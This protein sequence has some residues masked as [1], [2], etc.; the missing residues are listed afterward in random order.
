M[1]MLLKNW[2]LLIVVLVAISCSKN[3]NDCIDENKMKNEIGCTYEYNPV[4]GCDNKTYSNPCA[5]T[6]YGGV[7]SY[8]A[9]AC[10]VPKSCID[11][12]LICQN[13][14]CTADY[15]PVCGCDGV[16][17]SNGCIATSV[18]GITSFT[19]GECN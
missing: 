17:Y 2:F 15:T 4:C 3:N 16:T 10:E 5:A 14:M 11:S 1:N 19:E 8:T 6:N 7:K 9:G 18:Y 13:C 12:T